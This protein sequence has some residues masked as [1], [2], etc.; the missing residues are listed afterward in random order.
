MGL[1][2]RTET[3]APDV[4]E[5]AVLER[6]RAEAA[7]EA[8]RAAGIHADAVDAHGRRSSWAAECTAELVTHEQR[9]LVVPTSSVLV[10]RANA[11]RA[12]RLLCELGD[13]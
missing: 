2:S 9:M 4:V 7:V 13:E 10:S 5:V 1:F 11:A 3:T 12:R 8:L 6:W